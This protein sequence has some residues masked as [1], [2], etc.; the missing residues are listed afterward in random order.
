LGHA[1]TGPA[2][3]EELRETTFQKLFAA[4][5][6]RVLSVSA[7][8]IR[9]KILMFRFQSHSHSRWLAVTGLT[10]LLAS[11]LI[12]PLLGRHSSVHGQEIPA[13]SPL[14]V[15]RAHV[16]DSF[17]NTP[18]RFEKN[19]GQA[20]R[21]VE[22][23][24]HAGAYSV[25][26]TPHEALLSIALPSP[27]P[28][29]ASFL[30]KSGDTPKPPS[31]PVS[32]PV[33]LSLAGSNPSSRIT[34]LDP[35]PGQTN[36]L[37][38]KPDRWHK[39][40]PTFCRIQYR[41]VYPGIDLVYYGKQHQ[42]EYD[43]IVS[44]GA[45]P[46]RIALAFG[47][48]SASVDAGTGD[49]VVGSSA[50][51]LFRNK[52]PRAFQRINGREL[53]VPAFY[54]LDREHHARLQLGSYDVTRPLVIDPVVVFTTFLR[55]NNEDFVTGVAMD[56]SGA[57][58]IT[59]YTMSPDYPLLHDSAFPDIVKTCSAQS[60]SAQWCEPYAFVTKLTSNGSF[61]FSSYI[62][63]SGLDLPHGIGVDRASGRIFIAGFTGSTDF[64]VPNRTYAFG[65]GN[66][67]V[68]SISPVGD[69]YLYVTE[70]GGE[71]INDA[72]A[73]ALDGSDN[74][75]VTGITYSVDFPTSKYLPT[76]REP[77]QKAFGGVRDAFAFR[78]D[79]TGNMTYSTYIGGN[80]YDIGQGIAVDSKG[81][82]YVTGY[83]LST[84][85]P[86][87]GATPIG[88]PV[89]GGVTAFVIKLS[90]DG[91]RA[92]YSIYLGGFDTTTTAP[93]YDQG[94]A[95]AVNS[96]GQAYITG[97]T[98][99][100]NFPITPGALMP[101]Q[102]VPCSLANLN[103]PNSGF[104]TALTSSGA[105]LASTYLGWDRASQGNAIAINNAGEV[106]VGGYTEGSNFEGKPI[107]FTPNPYAGYV[108]KLAP[109]LRSYSWLN[110]LGASV[111]SLAVYDPPTRFI[112]LRGTQIAVGGYRWRP[113]S[114]VNSSVNLDGFLVKLRD[115]VVIR[116]PFDVDRQEAADP[117][118][119][120]SPDSSEAPSADS[121]R[122]F[123]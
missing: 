6:S 30:K 94:T 90:P 122:I 47:G 14:P 12:P 110:Y 1:L 100:T 54:R 59:G 32:V 112:A 66:A 85:F 24:S 37:V 70:V 64:G 69:R 29:P 116:L 31:V 35:L 92:P 25:A 123:E 4:S 44:P 39:D 73:M 56:N 79:S 67:F 106:Y 114:D 98:C 71:T 23:V 48:A 86:V 121:P 63:G 2:E 11:P 76:P 119:S 88:S 15:D 87:A 20:P 65:N 60:T 7:G 42:L 118:A 95:I 10:G 115:G 103:D 89:G 107:G 27:K 36:Y 80:D 21:P 5:P 62:G 72:Y 33:T 8:A 68:A 83:T 34:A 13:T 108:I 77:F 109:N 105:L 18:L 50:G 52:R 113:G 55:G 28:Q 111:T 16:V 120:S 84:N 22:Y 91:S 58:Y 81:N 104:V 17:R 96:S 40:V 74:V 51:T 53:E 19:V 3:L 99:S 97:L 45:D 101:S 61:L 78:L 43:F 82:A 26:F 117:S 49:L 75:Y 41:S 38:G 93:A 46:R 57:V 102:S 9:R